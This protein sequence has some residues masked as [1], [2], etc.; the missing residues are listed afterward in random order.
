MKTYFKID[1][2]STYEENI[3]A[4]L[5]FANQLGLNGNKISQ[6]DCVKGEN[7]TIFAIDLTLHDLSDLKRVVENFLC[8]YSMSKTKL[9]DGMIEPLKKIIED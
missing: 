3:Q 6:M 5:L 2:T 9:P 4:A 8:D 1:A 7:K